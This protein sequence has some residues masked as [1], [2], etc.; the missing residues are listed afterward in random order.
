LNTVTADPRVGNTIGGAGLTVEGATTEGA[1]ELSVVDVVFP[2]GASLV[3]VV[4]G[5]VVVVVIGGTVEVVVVGATVEVVV[6]ATVVV[7]VGATVEVVV[8]G[9]VVVV[10]V[11]VS[12]G[13]AIWNTV[14]YRLPEP[15][16]SVPVT[17]MVNTFPNSI[18]GTVTVNSGSVE[19][20][21]PSASMV[22]VH[23]PQL[24]PVL[25]LTVTDS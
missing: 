9:T 13:A 24:A 6:G 8:G 2:A 1:G 20:R 12:S 5:S 10:V 23:S 17:T 15:F 7:V 16:V 21:T 25:S 4:A 11:V 19:T 3:V 18:L 22:H 14:T